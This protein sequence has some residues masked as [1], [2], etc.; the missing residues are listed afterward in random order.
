[1]GKITMSKLSRRIFLKGTAAAIAAGLAGLDNGK[2]SWQGVSRP[3]VIRAQTNEVIL[4]IQ[5]FAHEAMKNILQDFEEET[6]LQVRLENSTASGVDLLNRLTTAFEAQTSPF[7]VVSLS[8][9]G[10]PRFMPRGWLESLENIITEETWG[11]FPSSLAEPIALWSSSEGVRYRVQ[12]ELAIGYFFTRQDWL[13]EKGLAAPTS[14]EEMIEIGLQ[15]TDPANDKWGTTDGL[16]RPGLMFVYVA[17]LATQ[18]GGQVFEFDDP[19]AQALQFL[20]DMIY[21][22]SIFPEAALTEDYTAQ[23]NRYLADQVAFMRQWPFF[24]DAAQTITEWYTPEKVKIALPPTGPNSARTWS[25]GHGFS[26]PSYAPNKE[27]G[28]ELIKYLTSNRIIA[29]LARE[30]A[31]FITPRNSVIEALG[32][33]EN[34]IVEALIA[35]SDADLIAPRPYHPRLAE[36]QT[37][38]DDVAAGFL[39]Q[40]ASLS[41]TIALGKELIAKLGEG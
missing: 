13:T 25:G 38:V 21:T 6:G 31:F 28:L 12:H 30:N 35:Y 41:E 27:G 1:M 10:M 40:Q 29:R 14:W 33:Q 4:G 20:Y 15:F 19:T 39:T 5:E 18:A 11:D 3:T 8:E 34:P 16:A 26:V 37:I 22:H 32:S 9:E 36:A 17:H 23:N 2:I 7:D 24:Q